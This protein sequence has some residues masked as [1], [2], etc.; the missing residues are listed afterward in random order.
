MVK[1]TPLYQFHASTVS[2]C[3]KVKSRSFPY[4][5]TKKFEIYQKKKTILEFHK[6]ET[7]SV[8]GSDKSTPI[9]SIM[10]TLLITQLN[11][12]LKFY[13]QSLFLNLIYYL[14]S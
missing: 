1:K 2:N 12:R 10:M 7:D 3:L 8:P 11:K 5:C 4:Q 6:N 13:S 9:S 14:L